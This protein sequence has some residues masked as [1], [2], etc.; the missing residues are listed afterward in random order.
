M[1][2]VDVNALKLGLK[3]TMFECHYHY[4]TPLLLKKMHAGN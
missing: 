1:L 3:N 4:L 2:A